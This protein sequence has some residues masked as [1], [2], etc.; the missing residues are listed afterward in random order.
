MRIGCYCRALSQEIKL[1]C[2][3]YQLIDE[4]CLLFCQIVS[5]TFQDSRTNLRQLSLT[6]GLVFHD[7]TCTPG[8]ERINHV[9]PLS[10]MQAPNSPHPLNVVRFFLGLL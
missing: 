4:N 8:A 3:I 7:S 10:F 9:P 6:Q 5:I 1:T 2:L